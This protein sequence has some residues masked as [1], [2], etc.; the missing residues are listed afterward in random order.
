VRILIVHFYCLNVAECE[1]TVLFF[2]AVWA[3]IGA[4]DLEL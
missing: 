2:L 1:Q 4:S 3:P